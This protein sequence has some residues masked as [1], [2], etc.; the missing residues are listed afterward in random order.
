MATASTDYIQRFEQRTARSKQLFE[1]ACEVTEGG[2]SH[3]PRYF[4]PYPLYVDKAQGSRVWDVDGNEYVDLWNGHSDSI[5]G[6]SPE[7]VV[8]KLREILGNGLHVGIPQEHEIA[9]AEKIQEMMPCAE[10]VS[11]CCSGTEATMFAVRIA[12]AHT[13]RNVILK[14]VGGWHGPNSEL[15][16]DVFPP[17]F[18]GAEGAGLTPDVPK[19]TRSVQMNDIEDTARAIREAG[20]DWAGVILST[21]GRAHI[22]VT[23]EYLQFLREETTKAGA[24]MILDEVVTGFRLAPGGA[25]EFYGVTPDLAC[26][27]KVMGGGLPIGGLAGKA[28]LFKNTA[29][30]FSGPKRDKVVIGGGTYSANPLSMV[31]GRVTLDLLARK[32]DTI[33]PQINGNSEKIANGARKAFEDAGIAVHV[34]NTG[35]MHEVH[36]L[37]EAGL[38][39]VTVKDCLANTLSERSKE[40]QIRMMNNGV[41]NLHGG[42]MTTAHG[43]AEVQH[44][45]GAYQKV[46]Q[47]MAAS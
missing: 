26:I 27:G 28:E 42:C 6:H 30:N 35:S 1:K 25:Q 34:L 38:P 15:L 33:Y 11:F 9:L 32:K 22:P 4:A 43:D 2:M 45:I 17:E 13:K 19:Y 40:V 41:Y 12:R 10:R 20:D 44:I 47:E 29:T 31:A 5:L 23:Q 39:M 46:A 36:V 7:P 14:M 8:S 16:V 24:V 3:V 37:K 21:V 18:I